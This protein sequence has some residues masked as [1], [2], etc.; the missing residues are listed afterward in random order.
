[1]EAN[2]Q[3]NLTGLLKRVTG[4]E[5]FRPGQEE[6]IRSVLAGRDT[7]AV[8]PTGAGKTLCYR[9][10]VH[11]T[12]GTVLIV[13]P[14]L[15]LMED[16]AARMKSEGEKSVAALNSFLTPAERSSILQN[17]G[18]YRYIF[19]SPEM[20]LQRRVSAR[21]KELRIAYIVAD[22]A[23]CISQWGFDF[24]PDYLR[25]REW[26]EGL[27]TRPPVMALT[28]TASARTIE[29]IEDYLMMDHPAKLIYPPD[30]PNIALRIIRPGG[31]Q[32]KTEWILRE[33]PASPAPGILYVQSRKRAEELS[34]MLRARGTSAA[35]FHAGMEKEDRMLVQQ[36][37]LNGELDWICAT[38]AFGMG[39]DKPDVRHV[40]HDQL[41]SSAAQYIQEIGRAGRDGNQSLA[42]LLYG[43]QDG[44]TAMFIA[45]D[46]LPDPVSIR[47]LAERM[48]EGGTPAH[49]GEEA[50]LSETALRVADYWINTDGAEGAA[51]RMEALAAEKRGE[52]SAMVRFAEGEGCI[53]E[54]LLALFGARPAGKTAQ[55]C[56]SC[57]LRLDE[58]PV[59]GRQAQRAPVLNGWKER[60]NL[61]FNVPPL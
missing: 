38:N 35:A 40:I 33:V 13:S 61:L 30:R 7:I 14:L 39:I 25:L 37:Y 16:Q 48:R 53:R 1:M 28:A 31:R 59:A 23:H 57:G 9:L 21:L 60:I 10:P 47:F 20:L 2:V 55:C 56:S 4:H 3:G 19:T 24:R 15:S 51:L 54:R 8:L 22:E 42:T 29:D 52:I 6:V 17:L 46:S 18:S 32:E 45:L 27:E 36:Q 5:A 50:G 11:L 49:A 41:P 44:E 26:L 12:G 34:E 43:E 58:M